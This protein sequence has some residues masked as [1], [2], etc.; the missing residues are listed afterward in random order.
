MHMIGYWAVRQEISEATHAP[1]H[2]TPIRRCFVAWC[3][4]TTGLWIP[5]S[6]RVANRLNLAT[7]NCDPLI[8]SAV[9]GDEVI[10]DDTVVLLGHVTGGRCRSGRARLVEDDDHDHFAMASIP[11]ET[12]GLTLASDPGGT[13]SA[14]GRPVVATPPSRTALRLLHLP[15]RYGLGSQSSSSSAT[16]VFVDATTLSRTFL[17]VAETARHLT[18]KST[19]SKRNGPNQ[20]RS[21]ERAAV[22]ATIGDI[23]NNAMTVVSDAR[24]KQHISR[25]DRDVRAGQYMLPFS[26]VARFEYLGKSAVGDPP[27]PMH[28]QDMTCPAQDSLR[29]PGTSAKPKLI[30]SAHQIFDAYEELSRADGRVTNSAAALDMPAC[31]SAA[32]LVMRVGDM[33]ANTADDTCLPATSPRTSRPQERPAVTPP[34]PSLRQPE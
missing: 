3:R 29:S 8:R 19:A 26:P 2:V 22:P 20:S 5:V 28:H 31:I 24:D 7:N 1:V 15:K 9:D 13:R 27:S 4:N 23:V 16:T 17:G 14:C 32:T 25:L 30:E 18:V 11:R 33:I 6:S 10:I 34:T 21:S 12:P